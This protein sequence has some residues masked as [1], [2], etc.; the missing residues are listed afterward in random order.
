MAQKGAHDKHLVLERGRWGWGW[1]CERTNLRGIERE[2]GEGERERE[3]EM[4]SERE[5]ESEGKALP[6]QGL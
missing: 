6:L 4:E 5:R 2:G 3:R 1:V